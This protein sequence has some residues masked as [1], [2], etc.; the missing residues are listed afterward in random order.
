VIHN[1][2]KEGC[3]AEIERRLGYRLVLQEATFTDRVKPGGLISLTVKLANVGF[4][5]PINPRPVYVVLDGPERFVTPLTAVDPRRWEAG[6]PASFSVQLRLPARAATG[7]YRLALWLP[8]AAD[9]LR[10]NPLYAVRFANL[11]IWD[12]ANGFNVLSEQL[13]LDL[14]AAGSRD[15]RATEFS[16]ITDQP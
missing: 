9:S 12:E 11:D 2:E 4:A 1:W 14:Q 5:S 16:V 6:R 3:L 15:S 10:D 13:I 7:V 8:D